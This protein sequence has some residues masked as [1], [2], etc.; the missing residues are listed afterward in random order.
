M[1][2]EFSSTWHKQSRI[3]Q[4]II[5]AKKYP[6]NNIKRKVTV[7]NAVAFFCSGTKLSI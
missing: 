3:F 7:Q 4:Q 5:D 1:K 2:K 6:I